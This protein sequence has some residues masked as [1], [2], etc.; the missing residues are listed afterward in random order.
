MIAAAR[1]TTIAYRNHGWK[2]VDRRRFHAPT[3]MNGT[4]TTE[5]MITA[6]LPIAATS[7]STRVWMIAAKPW[8]RNRWIVGTIV[9][10]FH[11]SMF[12]IHSALPD[13]AVGEIEP[14][15][16]S[17]RDHHG[18]ITTTYRPKQPI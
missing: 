15:T 3:R 12:R 17:C 10:E 9:I 4:R 2:S 13:D 7:P 6:K 14:K 11:S 5:P 18:A 1:K 8:S 16:A